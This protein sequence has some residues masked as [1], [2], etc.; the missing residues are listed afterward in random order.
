MMKLHHAVFAF[1]NG[2]AR[3]SRCLNRLDIYLTTPWN[4]APN[5]PRRN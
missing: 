2:I 1:P 3:T 4:I 5:P